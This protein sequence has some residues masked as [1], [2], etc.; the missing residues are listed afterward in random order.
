MGDLKKSSSVEVEV[1][2]IFT[3]IELWSSNCK[4]NSQK[5]IRIWVLRIYIVYG[6]QNRIVN[7]IIMFTPKYR[8]KVYYY[9]KRKVIGEILIKLYE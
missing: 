3:I 2:L 6:I 4:K 7:M 9:E 1:K 5:E 8:T